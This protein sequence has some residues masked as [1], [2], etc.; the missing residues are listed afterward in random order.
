[1]VKGNGFSLLDPVAGIEEGCFARPQGL[2]LTQ[3]N[4]PM[5]PLLF[6]LARLR[7]TFFPRNYGAKKELEFEGFFKG[8]PSLGFF[9]QGW[10]GDRTSPGV[11]NFL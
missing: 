10:G 3:I 6:F 9:T 2:W 1:M 11:S 7:E 5:G 8:E 4:G